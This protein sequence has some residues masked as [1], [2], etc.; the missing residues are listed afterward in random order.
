VTAYGE[1][2]KNPDHDT[3]DTRAGG[4]GKITTGVE[5]IRKK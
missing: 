1:G 4:L 5:V 3:D 2:L